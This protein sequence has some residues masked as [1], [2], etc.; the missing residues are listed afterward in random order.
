MDLPDEREEELASLQAIY[1]ELCFDGRDPFSATLDICVSP[2]KPL[3]VRFVPRTFAGSNGRSTSSEGPYIERDVPLSHLPPLQ[4]HLTL[5]THYPAESPPKVKL[6]TTYGWLP[7]ESILELE[8]Q[9]ESLWEEYGRCQILFSYI[10]YLQ[11]A[12]E[13]GFNLDQGTDGC[14]VLPLT[15]EPKLAAFNSETELHIFNAGTYDCGICL[16]PKKGSSCYRLPECGHVFC[17]SCLQDFY[18]NAI[19]EG[20]VASVRCLSPDC[21][22][23]QDIN[24]KRKR[25]SARA[26][27][28]SH[29]LAMEIDESLVRRYVELKRKKKL[30]ADKGTVYCPRTW[31]QGP[32]K[33]SK[34]PPIPADLTTYELD[35]A[36]EDE[37][38]TP[39]ANE[40]VS[41]SGT[42]KKTIPPNP[43]D[44]I[45]VCEKCSFAF[46]RVC[47]RGW[48]G[49]FA[50]CFPRDPNELSAEEKASYDYI[51]LNTSPCPTCSSPSQKTMGCNHMLCFQ[52]NTH[53]CYLCGSWLDGGNPYQHFNK[54]GTECYQRLWELE[55]GDEGQGPGDGRGFAGARAWEQLAIEAAREAEAR[56]AALAAQGEEDERAARALEEQEEVRLL[57]QPA[58][59]VVRLAQV[60]LDIDD[61]HDNVIEQQAAGNARRQRNA[62]PARRRAPGAANAVRN[63]ERNRA[64]NNRP[65]QRRP[66]LNNEERDQLQRFLD[67]AERD[68]EEEWDS[69]ELDDDDEGFRIR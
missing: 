33:S 46:C 15:E 44:R 23:D 26:L 31:C 22:K 56:E 54:S 47:Y 8:Q 4:L 62:F 13:Q 10:D 60:Q 41:T 39:A 52:C 27:H 21:G 12:A 35:F 11:Q 6:T 37:N 43:A 65:A 32:A 30:E 1:P 48:H 59:I 29:L 58:E 19:S 57:E 17:K 28:P 38:E 55:E 51:R 3:L 25:K 20:D 36:S 61:H 24:G 50:R 40:Q 42:E 34:Y 18:N 7:K 14:L 68:E 49:E 16:E 67:L 2:A 64:A 63:H 69:D 9:A 53:F 5:P 66:E 45:A